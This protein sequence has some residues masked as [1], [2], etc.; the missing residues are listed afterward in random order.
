MPDYI[1]QHKSSER[2]IHYSRHSKTR[3]KPLLPNTPVPIR[4]SVLRILTYVSFPVASTCNPISPFLLSL[5]ANRLFV[6][7]KKIGPDRI[8][9]ECF[10]STGVLEIE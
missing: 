7:R 5:S 6:S 2:Q 3:G 9:Q 10:R 1:R 8:Q 4:N